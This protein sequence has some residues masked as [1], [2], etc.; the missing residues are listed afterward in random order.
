MW[1]SVL[2]QFLKPLRKVRWTTSQNSQPVNPETRAWL[3]W[4]M[5]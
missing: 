2:T 3:R 5:A 4:P 1:K